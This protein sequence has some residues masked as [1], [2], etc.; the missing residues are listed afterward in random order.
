MVSVAVKVDLLGVPA[1]ALQAWDSRLV[2]GEPVYLVLLMNVGANY[3]VNFD[4]PTSGQVRF[5]VGISSH[6]KPSKAAISTAFRAHSS[7]PYTRES[8]PPRQ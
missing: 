2:T 8:H 4:R 5:R 7:N 3:P 6:Y 1:R